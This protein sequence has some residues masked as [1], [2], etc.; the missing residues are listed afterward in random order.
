VVVGDEVV[1]S[2]MGGVF[3][4]GIPVGRVT[5]VER[6]SGALFQEAVL[7]PKVDLSRLEEV[8]ILM[9][10]EPREGFE[11]GSRRQP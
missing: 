2:G 6:K 5:T 10:S 11:T 1:T 7:Q 3:P 9:N 8:V 4:R